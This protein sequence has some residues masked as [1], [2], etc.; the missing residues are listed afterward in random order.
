MRGGEEK[1]KG[2]GG[3]IWVSGGLDPV[4]KP[5]IGGTVVGQIA[6]IKTNGLQ[7]KL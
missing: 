2:G 1:T 7:P 5:A 3:L 4:S 6:L